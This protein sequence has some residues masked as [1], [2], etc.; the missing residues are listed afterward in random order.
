VRIATKLA[1]TAGLRAA[2]LRV[3][4]FHRILQQ[5]NLCCFL[6][7]AALSDERVTLDDEEGWETPVELTGN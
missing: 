3:A 1:I 7:V 5:Q 6:M 2:T 4:F